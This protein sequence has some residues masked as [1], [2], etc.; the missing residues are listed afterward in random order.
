M[1][2]Y[3]NADNATCLDSLGVE[4]IPKDIYRTQ[5]YDSIMGGYFCIGFIYFMLKGKICWTIHIYFLLT[6]KK[7]MII[8]K[9]FH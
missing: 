7:R 8:L 1:N 6:N 5:A 2:S 4:N 3:M 9:Y